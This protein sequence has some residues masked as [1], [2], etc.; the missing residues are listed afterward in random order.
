MS[1]QQELKRLKDRTHAWIN[2]KYPKTGVCQNPDCEKI[3][4][5]RT[6]YANLCNHKY[7]KDIKDYMEMCTS[8]H[9]KY[10]MTEERTE[11]TASYNRGKSAWWN[12]IPV[13]ATTEEIT[14]EF[15]STR[16]A[17]KILGISNTAIVNCLKGRAKTSGGFNWSYQ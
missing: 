9:K 15:L 14:L 3:L 8:C 7:T 12:A 13:K 17:E 11:K 10:D 2:R 16:E 5:R 4:C 1:N 6:E